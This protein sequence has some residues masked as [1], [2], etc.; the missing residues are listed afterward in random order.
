M[1]SVC[2][3]LFDF[4]TL[5]G[6]KKQL[7]WNLYSTYHIQT[8]YIIYWTSDTLS[9]TK[10][11]N[12]KQIENNTSVSSQVTSYIFYIESINIHTLVEKLEQEHVRGHTYII[13]TNKRCFV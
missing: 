5:V 12:H 2:L 3:C 1:C 8:H 13:L 7:S 4:L 10:Q 9:Y 11:T 6:Y